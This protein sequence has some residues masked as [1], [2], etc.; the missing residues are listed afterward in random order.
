MISTTHLHITTFVRKRCFFKK[1]MWAIPMKCRPWVVFL[2]LVSITQ[3]IL[4]SFTIP[5][6]FQ[7]ITIFSCEHIFEIILYR[8][9]EK[10]WR[11]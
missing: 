8:L 1:Y 11:K 5:F 3:R 4:H 10:L 9:C 7:Y 6:A 2:A